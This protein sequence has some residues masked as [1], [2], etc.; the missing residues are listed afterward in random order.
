MSEN[1][2]GSIDTA[3]QAD[4][5]L[6]T[7]E[8]PS[9]N[10]G[11][12]QDTPPPQ[13][14]T[15]DEWDLTVGGKQIKAKRDQIMQWAQQ[16]YSAPGKIAQYTRELE[17]MKKKWTEAEPKYKELETKY[18]PVDEYVRQNPQFWDHVVQQFEQRQ[19][20]TQDPSNPLASEIG[21]LRQQLQELTQFKSSFEQMQEKQRLEQDDQKYMQ[22]VGELKKSYP[23]VDFDTVDH[24][25]KSLEMKVLEYGIQNKISNFKTAFKDFYHDEL[26]KRA[27]AKAKE[28]VAKERMK[29]TKLGI[30]G[31]TP[32]STKQVSTDHRG[33]SYDDIANEIKQEYGL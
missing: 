12:V 19:Q 15:Q 25:G 22:T 7:I 17:D 13:A 28:S 5:V 30:L 33:K 31:I 6:E 3:E 18:G 4:A 14:Q 26:I 23:D 32:A 21:S 11:P 9:R 16:G 2:F 8:Q 27:E 24:E 20:L 1:D 10:S 29:S